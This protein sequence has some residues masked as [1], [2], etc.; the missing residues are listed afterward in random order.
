MI[1]VFIFWQ[2][3][4]FGNQESTAERVLLIVEGPAAWKLYSSFLSYGRNII[5]KKS[6]WPP[7]DD[8]SHFSDF[9]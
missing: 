6:N 3:F 4:Q 2:F 5:D 7:H 1:T 9:A 8:D